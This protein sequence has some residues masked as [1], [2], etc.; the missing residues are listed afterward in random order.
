MIGKCRMGK[1]PGPGLSPMPNPSG[2]ELRARQMEKE[3]AAADV[4]KV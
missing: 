2:K 3:A 4:T 1:T